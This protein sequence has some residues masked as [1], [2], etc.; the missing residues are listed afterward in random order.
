MAAGGGVLE[1]RIHGSSSSPTPH[2][3]LR[4]CLAGRSTPRR[5]RPL[6][7]VWVVVAVSEGSWWVSVA[8]GIHVDRPGSPRRL[9]RTPTSVRGRCVRRPNF[10]WWGSCAYHSSGGPVLGQLGGGACCSALRERP[11]PPVGSSRV[12]V[13]EDRCRSSS[14]EGGR[15]FGVSP[16]TQVGRTAVRST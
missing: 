14:S 2:R 11:L 8:L 1:M 3:P 15:P 4:E 16:P 10:E 9:R 5:R 7:S 13:A 12:V 6:G